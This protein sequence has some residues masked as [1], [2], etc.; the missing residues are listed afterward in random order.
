[1]SKSGI[2]VVRTWAFNGANS[3]RPS[4]RFSLFG[5]IDV[6][7]IPDAGSWLLLI[8]NGNTTVNFGSNGIQRLDK[9]IQF[10]K[11]FNIYVFFS[12][13]NNWFPTVNALPPSPGSSPLPRNY[14]SNHY[15]QC[16]ILDLL[17]AFVV[18]VNWIPY[19][20]YGCLCS[21]VWCKEDA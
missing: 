3:L 10:A 21:G 1:M 8:Q 9:V 2:T 6:T 4:L 19:R 20:R 13:T 18:V 7:T 14:L 11:E 12:L 5:Q 17:C 15:G 16:I